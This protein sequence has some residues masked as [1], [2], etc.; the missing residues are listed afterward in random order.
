MQRM[1]HQSYW[2]LG[3]RERDTKID[4]QDKDAL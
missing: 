4:N 1:I 3:N 2:M